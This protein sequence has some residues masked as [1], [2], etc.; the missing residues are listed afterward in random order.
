MKHFQPLS[1]ALGLLS[2]FLILLILVKGWDLV[3]PSQ[4]N[5]YF[6]A[7]G[8]NQPF[9]SGQGGGGGFNISRMAERLG[10]TEADLQKELDS[11]KTFQEIAQE[12]G[13]PLGGGFGRRNGGLQ[14][15]T[16]SALP[17]SASGQIVSTTSSSSSIQ[18]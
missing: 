13:V 5:G 12:R 15:G 2:G 14:N 9:G 6:R 10:M 18:P 4:N 11:G 7:N 1:F 3:H 17:A 8:N 16:G